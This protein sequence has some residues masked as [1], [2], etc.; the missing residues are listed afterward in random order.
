LP[1]FLITYVFLVRTNKCKSTAM[2]ILVYINGFYPA[3]GGIENLTINLIKEFVANGHQVR[4]ITEQKDAQSLP[5]I[6]VYHTSKVFTS[7]KLFLWSDVFYMPNVSLKGIWLMLFNPFKNW[8][9]SHNDYSLHNQHTLLS[10]IKRLVSNLTTQN[11]SVS[12]SLAAVLKARSKV[13]YNCYDDDVFKLEPNLPRS[14]DFAFVGRLV[15]QKGCDHLIQAC[16]NLT[17][18]F[19]LNIAGDGPEKFYLSGLVQTYNLTDSIKFVGELQGPQLAIM[20]NQ[21]K[22]LVIPSARE[23]GFGIVALEGMA[24]GCRIVAS[25]AGGL[26]EAV[27]AYGQLFPMGD[28]DQLTRLLQSELNNVKKPIPQTNPGQ[29]KYLRNHTKNV[30]AQQYLSVFGYS[31]VANQNSTIKKMVNG[32]YSS[33]S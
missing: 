18:P 12:K 29:Q 33:A 22:T 16:R 19:T 9:I 14:Y 13:V 6:K 30:I 10:K 21:H 4:V 7:I 20:L 27:D 32:T 3:V 17:E 31:P 15:S 8:V 28:V 11:I 2:K 24:C 23:E 25:N 26:S 5:G 1:W